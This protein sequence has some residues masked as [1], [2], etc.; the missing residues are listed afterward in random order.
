MSISFMFPFSAM[1]VLL[2]GVCVFWCSS[3]TKWTVSFPT[4]HFQNTF[5]LDSFVA[6]RGNGDFVVKPSSHQLPTPRSD[7]SSYEGNMEEGKMHGQGRFV[8]RWRSWPFGPLKTVG[9]V[10][11]KTEGNDFMEVK[12][13]RASPKTMD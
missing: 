5:R 10:S 11:G 1:P 2:L 9:S 12:C 3:N 7:G 8:P 6:F 4:N 13:I